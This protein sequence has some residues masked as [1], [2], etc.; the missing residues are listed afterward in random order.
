MSVKI[1]KNGNFEMATLLGASFTTGNYKSADGM[2]SKIQRKRLYLEV[3]DD[4]DKAILTK[5]G[6]TLYKATEPDENGELHEFF[7]VPVAGKLTVMYSQSKS[8]Q[9]GVVLDDTVP[10]FTADDVDVVVSRSKSTQG[11][12]MSRIVAIRYND[13]A[14]IEV[15][16]QPFFDEADGVE[17]TNVKDIEAN[18]QNLIEN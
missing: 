10:N 14:K 18:A 13:T 1:E 17:Y 8:K 2:E 4:A 11:Q 6:L 16:E 5:F 15:F 3:K 12:M 7:I 9:T